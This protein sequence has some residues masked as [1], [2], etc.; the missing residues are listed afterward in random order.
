MNYCLIQ[1]LIQKTSSNPS[2]FLQLKDKHRSI[3]YKIK[4]EMINSTINIDNGKQ[5]LEEY[6]AYLNKSKNN[7]KPFVEESLSHLGTSTKT[8]RNISRKSSQVGINRQKMGKRKEK[9]E[10]EIGK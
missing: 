7:K 1:Q 5:I 10:E 2:K 8:S 4:E 9:S 3:L 6:C